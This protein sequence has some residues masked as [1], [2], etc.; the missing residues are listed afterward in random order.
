MIRPSRGTHIIVPRG[1]AAGGGGGDRAGRRRAHDLRAAVA[2]ADADRHH[3]QGLR[4]RP[5]AR[6][7]VRGG[8]GVPAGR[9]QR[10]LREL[11]RGRRHR[12]RLRR[13][14]AADLDRRSA[15]VGR[16]LAQGRAVR[17]LERDDHHHRRQAHDVAADGEDDRRPDRRARGP[18]RALRDPSGAAR[19]AG[20]RRRAAARG[21]RAGGGVRAARRPLRPCRARR[22]AGRGRAAGA[23]RPDPAGDAGPAGRG[24]LRR[25]QRAG[26]HG[27]RRAAAPHPAGPDRRARGERAGDAPRARWPS[28]GAPSSGIDAERAARPTPSRAKRLAEGVVV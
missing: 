6:A 21:R 9:R 28:A 26:P 10:V 23:G 17:D 20:R 13:R 16:H 2:G 15:Q 11:A 7:A 27:R 14:A 3:R 8:R 18:R 22:A 5:R 4:G 12:G 19:P 24:R 1:E 25:A